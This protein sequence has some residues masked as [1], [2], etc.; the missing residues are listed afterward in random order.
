MLSQETSRRAASR[1]QADN[2]TAPAEP[3]FSPEPHES[4]LSWDT[5]LHSA[6]VSN[7][8]TSL[9][10]IVKPEHPFTFPGDENVPE[11]G[12]YTSPIGGSRVALLT[13]QISPPA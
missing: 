13:K 8:K 12:S 7:H 6:S 3:A 9:R 4:F 2:H 1:Y 11:F 5:Q 10:S